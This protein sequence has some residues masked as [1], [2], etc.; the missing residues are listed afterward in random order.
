MIIRDPKPEDLADFVGMVRDF[1]KEGVDKY[2][3]GYDEDSTIQAF[4]LWQKNPRTISF[5]LEHEGSVVG[6]ITGI[7]SPH[8]FNGH[9]WYYYE[10]FWYI[11][12]EFRN[13]GYGIKLFL[14]TVN[15]CEKRGIKHLVM[16]NQKHFLGDY[17]DSIFTR[18]GFE[19][20]ENVWIR[21]V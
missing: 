18:L 16:A 20:M 3:F 14:A 7:T 19:P 15:E 13:H 11:R 5:M 12:P 21:K 6:I 2:G 8:F 1:M 9:N 4:F 10:H 17:F